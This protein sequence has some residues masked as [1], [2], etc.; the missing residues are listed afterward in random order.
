MWASITCTGTWPALAWMA[1]KS[2]ARAAGSW[3]DWPSLSRPETPRAGSRIFTGPRAWAHFLPMSAP[4]T[5]F[6]SGVVRMRVTLA[7]CLWSWRARY[8]SGTVSR[9]KKLTMSQAPTLTTWGMPRSPAARRRSGPADSSPPTNSSAS[10]VVVMSSTPEM[11]PSRMSDSMAW[12]P[13]P[14]AWK[15]RT[16]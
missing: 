4:M 9:P 12:P 14:V 6:S 2:A 3:K 11:S 13:L 5:A 15:T 16:S 1:A 10:S 7:L 8:F